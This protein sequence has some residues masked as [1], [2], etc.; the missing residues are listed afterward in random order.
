MFTLLEVLSKAVE[1]TGRVARFVVEA[2]STRVAGAQLQC[3]FWVCLWRT[4]SPI[5][6]SGVTEQKYRRTMK[7]WGL[8][9]S[10][11][12]SHRM[13]ALVVM[14]SS[15]SATRHW[16]TF[17]LPPLSYNPGKPR[18][19]WVEEGGRGQC[20]RHTCRWM[21]SPLAATPPSSRRVLHA[22][23]SRVSSG[24]MHFASR[25]VSPVFTVATK[26]CWKWRLIYKPADSKTWFNLI[27]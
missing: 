22:Q 25:F 7:R 6:S 21:C 1:S 8:R 26:L 24:K 4:T 16:V 5:S 12:T 14:K 15:S 3:S 9:V 2:L 19:G 27:V 10:L 18:N 13:P 11:P 20:C 23:G 17:R